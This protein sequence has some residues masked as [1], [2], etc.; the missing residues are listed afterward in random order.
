[1]KRG[2]EVQGCLEVLSEDVHALDSIVLKHCEQYYSGETR[3]ERKGRGLNILLGLK[4][5]N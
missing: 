3:N 5:V 2:D 4:S 1:M